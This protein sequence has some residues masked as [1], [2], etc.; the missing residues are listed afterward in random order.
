MPDLAKIQE[1]LSFQLLCQ[2]RWRSCAVLFALAV[3]PFC[4]IFVGAIYFN[5]SVLDFLLAQDSRH[6]W[7]FGGLVMVYFLSLSALHVF[8]AN[9]YHEDANTQVEF[10]LKERGDH[11]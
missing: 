5:G 4:L 7:Y 6:V 10:V 3:L 11:Y 9:N 2:R 8:V 1:D